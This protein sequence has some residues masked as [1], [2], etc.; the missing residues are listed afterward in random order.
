VQLQ[1]VLSNVVWILCLAVGAIRAN[2]DDALLEAAK[3]FSVAE[4]SDAQVLAMLPIAGT[5]LIPGAY[6]LLT[7]TVTAG[8]GGNA[9]IPTG[10]KAVFGSICNFAV[11][12]GAT[13]PTGTSVDFLCQADVAGPI[14]VTPGKVTEFQTT[15]ANVAA[16]TNAAGAIPGRYAETV[17]QARQRLLAGNIADIGLDGTVNAIRAVQGITDAMIF[18]NYDTVNPL[19]LTGAISIPCRQAC[20]VVVGSDETDEAIAAAYAKR[21]NSP[22]IG[23]SSQVYTTLSGQSLT[24]SFYEATSQ[25]IYVQVYYDP[26]TV[27]ASGF[28]DEIADMVASIVWRVGKPVTSA[29]VAQGLIGFQHAL[30]TGCR[31]SVDDAIWDDEVLINANKY[32]SVAAADVHVLEEP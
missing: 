14:E 19:V 30:V 21:M 2:D 17:Q 6:S 7:L 16:V 4:A 11:L 24:V 27:T 13:V 12:A 29:Q 18:F 15:I 25:R 5:V 1:A 3:Q 20:I 10:A 28:E 22:T 31:V 8:P 23:T 9:V 32:G 26:D